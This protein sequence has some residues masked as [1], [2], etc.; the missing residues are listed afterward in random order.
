MPDDDTPRKAANPGIFYYNHKQTASESYF[1]HAHHGIELLYV[2][3]GQGEIMLDNRTFALEPG[4]LV[5][6]QPYQMHRVEVPPHNGLY[7]RSVLTFDPH[8]LEPY[9]VPFPELKLY[10]QWI[11][12]GGMPQQIFKLNPDSRV[13]GL[14][15][16]LYE[17]M[18]QDLNGTEENR[19]LLLLLLLRQ[20]K[21]EVLPALPAGS[22]PSPRMQRYMESM[23]E[24]LER[25]YQ[26]PF[27]LDGMANELHLSPYHVSHLFK[28]NTG[29]TISRYL[30][31]RR[32]R[33][34]CFL[35]AN[36]AKPVHEIAWLVG[37]FNS[38]YFCKI[39][40]ENKGLS[41]E[42]YRKAYRENR[43]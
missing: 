36:T 37:R 41:P 8:L 19:A 30:T 6:F 7:T 35:L 14:L 3:T 31:L 25:H 4:T 10:F 32:I 17:E 21:R 2:Y 42:N 5:W 12:R 40:K 24:W 15:D 27:S 1:F 18:N 33:E 13:I 29:I 34:A 16:E 26:E 20:L 11:W 28:Q 22:H 9:L 23:T 43:R 39:F 38:A